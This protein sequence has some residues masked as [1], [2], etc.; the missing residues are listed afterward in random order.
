M[1]ATRASYSTAIASQLVDRVAR[2]DDDDLGVRILHHCLAAEPRR[3]RH[4]RRL[5][6]EVL[7]ALLRRRELL[8]SPLHDHVTRGAGAIPTAGV[9]EVN[10]VREQDVED[11]A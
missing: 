2:H 11:R 8:G 6:E 3:R 7:L 10:A 1:R 4:A 5:I 9:I